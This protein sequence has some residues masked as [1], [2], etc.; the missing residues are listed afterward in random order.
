M[1]RFV[2]FPMSQSIELKPGETYRGYISVSNPMDSGSDFD[3]KVT[4][5]PYS[6]MDENY[7][8]DFA[9]KNDASQIV[10][11][12][13]LEKTS[14]TI[15]PND[16][17][18]IYFKIN[19]PETAPAGG[20]YA[21]INVGS[22][23]DK[24]VMDG[25]GVVD[26]F[27]MS[28]VIFAAVDGETVHAGEYKGVKIPGF[29]TEPSITTVAEYRNDG[30]VHE[31]ASVAATITDALTGEVIYPKEGESNT[32]VE[33]I[34]PGTTRVQTRELGGMGGLGLYTVKEEISYMDETHIAQQNVIVCPIW[35]VCLVV[36]LFAVAFATV[37]RI[38]KKNKKTKAKFAEMDKPEN[39]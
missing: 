32:L 39:E 7:T 8:A 25:S 19:V 2:V 15:K 21:V 3:Y 13:T 23:P 28:S 35:F 12:V 37:F 4:V 1:S 30:N 31:A 27:E 5:G 24:V 6:V 38:V 33:M 11:W 9:S 20:Q 34:M 16:V 14:G 18:R 17:E 22:D 36:V 26:T 10:D 29:T